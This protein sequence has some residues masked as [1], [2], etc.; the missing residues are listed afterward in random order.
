MNEVAGKEGPKLAID[1]ITSLTAASRGGLD[2]KPGSPGTRDVDG[3]RNSR[4]L[5]GNA[6]KRLTLCLSRPTPATRLFVSLGTFV[7]TIRKRIDLKLENS[8]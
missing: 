6:A 4:H 8:H 2:A 7:L 1:E 5:Y 3:C